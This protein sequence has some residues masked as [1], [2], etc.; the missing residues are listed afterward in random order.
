MLLAT[1]VVRLTA[2]IFLL[3][4]LGFVFAPESLSLMSTGSVP[5]TLSGVID[6]RATYGGLSLGV[7]FLL[8]V[9]AA[10]HATLR[11]GVLGVALLMAGM[12]SGRFV[13][14]MLDGDANSLMWS[15]LLL[16]IIATVFAAWILVRLRTRVTL[17]SH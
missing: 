7:A 5:N 14:I 12:A 15:Y 17:E 13:G 1:I 8:W 4:G 16:E 9:L 10:S 3:F 11:A 6:M 2:L